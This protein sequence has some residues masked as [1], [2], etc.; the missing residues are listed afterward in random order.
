MLLLDLY[1]SSPVCPQTDI[2]E[3]LRELQKFIYLQ[4]KVI[5]FTTHLNEKMLRTVTDQKKKFS[6]TKHDESFGSKVAN[7]NDE[8]TFFER[9]LPCE[10]E[11]VPLLFADLK[12]PYKR[13]RLLPHIHSKNV[14][15]SRAKVEEKLDS[16]QTLSTRSVCGNKGKVVRRSGKSLIQFKLESISTWQAFDFF[17]A[18]S[19]KSQ[20]C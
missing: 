8:Y 19:T 10:A 3:S 13:F 11:K 12:G 17:S 1:G 14:K 16:V 5:Y 2:P 18:L 20:T 7:A 9:K 6:L 15:N 4:L